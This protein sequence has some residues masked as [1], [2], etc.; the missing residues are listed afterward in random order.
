[1]EKTLFDTILYKVLLLI[2][3]LHSTFK[4]KLIMH[5]NAL[6]YKSTLRYLIKSIQNYEYSR[7]N[8]Y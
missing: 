3:L 7:S 8:Y 2:H 5:M 1:M 4:S 6:L